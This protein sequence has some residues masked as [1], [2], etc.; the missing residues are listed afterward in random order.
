MI[1]RFTQ[2]VDFLADLKEQ[3]SNLAAVNLRRLED[4]LEPVEA[5]LEVLVVSAEDPDEVELT[6]EPILAEWQLMIVDD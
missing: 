2:S 1:V 5:P 3:V 4:G 6:G